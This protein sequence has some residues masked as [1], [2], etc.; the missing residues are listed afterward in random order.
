MTIAYRVRSGGLDER[1]KCRTAAD[2]RVIA[3]IAIDRAGGNIT[4]SIKLGQ[5]VEVRG[6]GY[7]GDATIYFAAEQLLA[8]LGLGGS[9]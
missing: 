5:I 2:P 9:T 8:D 6:G 4:S 1:I 7:V 3:C